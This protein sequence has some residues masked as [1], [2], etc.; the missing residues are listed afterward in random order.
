VLNRLLAPWKREAAALLLIAFVAGRGYMETGSESAGWVAAGA[1]VLLFALL[2]GVLI[3]T[4]FRP[5]VRER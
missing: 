1:N 4:T 3:H 2:V 5:S